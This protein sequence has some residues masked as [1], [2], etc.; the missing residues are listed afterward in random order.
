MVSEL[1]EGVGSGFLV[2]GFVGAF[3]DAGFRRFRV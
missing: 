1:A 3:M 2:F